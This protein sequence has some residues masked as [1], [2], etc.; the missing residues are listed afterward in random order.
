MTASA[1]SAA[2]ARLKSTTDTIK[3]DREAFRAKARA[4][5]GK[6]PVQPLALLEAIGAMLPK[7]AVVIEEILSSAPGIAHADQQRRRAELLRPARRRHRLGTAGG[8]RR[9]AGAARPA[10]GGAD[11]RRQR[12]VHDAGACG[13]RRITGCRSIWVIFNNTSY[14]ILKQRLVMLRGL[15][16]QADKFVGMELN[17]PAIDFVGLARSLG[18]DG[19]ARHD[20]AGRHRPDR[21]GAQGRQRDADRRRH[22]AR[23]QA[24]VRDPRFPEAVQHEVA[25]R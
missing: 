2:S 10:G 16:E 23:L 1:K 12:H 3:K 8:D 24:D 6:T 13:P 25:H 22:G 9:Q 15:A 4:M 19:A 7:D 5:A 17:D 20:R 11:R 21:Q 18:I 14:R